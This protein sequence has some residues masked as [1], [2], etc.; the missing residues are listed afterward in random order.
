MENSNECKEMNPEE[1]E[2]A[3]GGIIDHTLQSIRCP[4]CG[5]EVHFTDFDILYDREIS[6]PMCRLIIK[7]G[8]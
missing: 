8:V 7:Q 4:R 1:L 2:H 5:F 6:C 3:S